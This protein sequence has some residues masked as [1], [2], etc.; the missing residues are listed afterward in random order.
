MWSTFQAALKPLSVITLLSGR[1][2]PV[3]LGFFQTEEMLTL[4]SLP[5]G[6]KFSDSLPFRFNEKEKFIPP[7]KESATE[8][9]VLMPVSRISFVSTPGFMGRM[10]SFHFR[11]MFSLIP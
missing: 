10:V 8:I 7:F 6:I 4:F 5:S 3:K 9:F 1:N 11:L 2:E